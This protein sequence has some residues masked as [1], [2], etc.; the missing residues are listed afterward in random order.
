MRSR[1]SSRR[2]PPH[3]DAILERGLRHRGQP[4]AGRD[5]LGLPVRD[6]PEGERPLGEG[7]RQ[8]APGVDQLVQLQVKRSKQRADHRPVQLLPDQRE[9]DEPMQGRLELVTDTLPLVRGLERRQ[10]GGCRG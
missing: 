10:I 7:V 8:L 2:P 6:E 9:V 1:A 5:G 3:H 4:R